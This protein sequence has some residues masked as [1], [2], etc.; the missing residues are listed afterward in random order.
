MSVALYD[1]ARARTFEPFALT[2]P[3]SEMRAGAVLM[4]RRWERALET[5]A[6]GLIVATHLREFEDPDSPPVLH[7]DIPAGTVIA[8]AR[9][10]I[11]LDTLPAADAWRVEG[12]IAG[13]RLPV[14][15]ASGDLR[16]GRLDLASLV[17]PG[18]RVVDVIGWW[19]DQ[20]WD[21]VRFLPALLEHDIE[22]LAEAIELERGLH[23]TKIGD[24]P[25]YVERGARIDPFVIFDCH[26]GPIVV[27]RGAEV[28][29]FTRLVGP[30]AVGT[31][32]RVLGG[33]ISTSS[34]GDASRVAGEVSHT[35]FTGHA[36]K[37]HDGFLGHSILGRWVNLGA[38]TVTSNLKNT[39]GPVSLWT[40][41]GR[42][43]TGLQ[44][45]GT[46]AG[47]H[48]KTAIGTRL[49]TGTVLGAASNVF[50][51]RDP[52]KVVQPFS[53]GLR[54]EAYEIDRFLAVA[55]RVMVRR[56]VVL[57]PRMRRT[58]ERAFAERWTVTL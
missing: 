14:P 26:A 36:N 25:A 33:K 4:R 48:V 45:L 13:V 27:R 42:R 1:D 49:T 23:L 19:I 43:D 44:F 39:Y 40:P 56:N 12:R 17:A 50:G 6:T 9:C 11:T 46:L 7:D 2:R 51:D 35:I 3:A 10:A 24:Y 34:I 58:L 8:N 57:T 22:C 20:V 21:Y 32:A 37:A 31:D 28:A 53:W 30:C 15:L 38:S 54:G 5:V 18:S 16:D 41:D 29:A 55:E 47:D 52:P